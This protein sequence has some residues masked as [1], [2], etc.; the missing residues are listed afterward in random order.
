MS[1][2]ATIVYHKPMV[3]AE[4]GCNHMGELDVAK[5]LL[6]LAK[7]SGCDY[8]KFQKRCPKELL[9]AEQY[10]AP[11]PNPRNSYGD[12][13][14][15]HREFLELTVDHHRILQKHC[16]EI[17]LGYSCS[18]WDVTS[19]KEIVSLNPALIKVGSPTNLHFEMQ[20]ILRDQYTGDVHISTGMTT[21]DEVERIVKFWEEGK[22]DAKNRLV[23]Y[24]CT[25]G[26]PVPFE[27]VCLLELRELYNKYAGRVKHIG[28]SGHHLGIAVDVAAYAMGATW[29]ERHFTKDRTWKGTDHAAS[30]EPAG[31]TKLC[32]DLQAT[33]KCM[34]Q[35]PTE[36]L[37]I[38]SAQRAKLKYGCFDK[39]KLVK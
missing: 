24:N 7:Q 23:L 29:N 37:P 3:M 10:N 21:K 19:A 18:V 17:G 32:R 20:A 9:S 8:G 14:G 25:S 22:G 2:P 35:K 28:F 15:A 39:D 27:D 12:T 13:Y 36:I 38:E 34:T 4:I 11:H 30:L 6:T 26:Y 33:Y 31:L 1:E 16:E 5:E